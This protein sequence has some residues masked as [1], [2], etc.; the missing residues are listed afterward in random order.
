[1]KQRDTLRLRCG[2]KKIF[3]DSVCPISYPLSTRNDGRKVG[4]ETEHIAGELDFASMGAPKYRLL[5]IVLSRYRN[6]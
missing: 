1:M 5:Y 2:S 4:D 6:I 3:A